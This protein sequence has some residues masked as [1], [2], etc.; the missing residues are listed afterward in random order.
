[1]SAINTNGTE[2]LRTLLSLVN[3][4]LYPQALQGGEGNRAEIRELVSGIM[5]DPRNEKMD[6]SG[7]ELADLKKRLAELEERLTK[8]R[9]EAEKSNT[10]IPMLELQRRFNLNEAELLFLT[11]VLAEALDERYARFYT[12]MQ[13][14]EF[15]KTSFLLNLLNRSG[16]DRYANMCWLQR[17]G[18][19]VTNALIEPIDAEIIDL[20]TRFRPAFGIPE[21][22][23][24][25]N[26][27]DIYGTRAELKSA[28]EMTYEAYASKPTVPLAVTNAVEMAEIGQETVPM[29]SLYGPD[30]FLLLS[31][32][33]DI[34]MEMNRPLLKLDLKGLSPQDSLPLLRYALRDCVLNHAVLV[35]FGLNEQIDSGGVMPTAIGKALMNSAV[36]VVFITNRSFVFKPVDFDESRCMLRCSIEFMTGSERFGIWK[37]ELALLPCTEEVDDRALR[38]LAGQF[39]LTY[40][41]IRSAVSTALGIAIREDRELNVEDLYEG[42]RGSS[43]HHLAELADKMPPRYNL[44]DLIL[45]DKQK[46][47]LM[48]LINMV[49]NRSM[50]LED[51]GVQKKLVSG[52]GISALFTGAPGTGKTLSAQVIAG[53]LGLELYRVDLSTIVSK[54]IGETEKN[55]ERIFDEASSSNVILF[56]DEADSLFGKRSDVGDSHDRYANIEVGYLLQRIETYDGIVLMATN[57]GANLDEAFTRRIHFIIDYPFPD[58]PTR[59]RLWEL[60]IPKNIACDA[61]VKLSEFAAA[62]K[63]AG[64]NIRNAVVTAVYEA[65][66]NDSKKIDKAGLLRGVEREYQKMGKVFKE[67]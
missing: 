43:M 3:L 60:L 49:K 23:S 33:S 47:E 51:W 14:S 31:A 12:L 11:A 32:A 24:G 63:I 57:L 39:A 50:V 62:Y 64:G 58:E 22:L 35:L 67:I 46:R 65:A 7:E 59:L 13:G 29:I 19:L 66:A 36:P 53:E 52:K 16:T 54:Y 28:P 27:L 55:L 4:Q 45:P 5:E 10:P 44:S 26:R 20:D 6:V 25:Q 15:P 1:M 41:Q 8:L 38:T 48:D 61:D 21:W 2:Y 56:F 30:E 40:A 9:D 42:A 17:D 34:S 18:R 37:N